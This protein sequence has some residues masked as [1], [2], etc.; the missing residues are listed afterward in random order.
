MYPAVP[1]D[2]ASA[3]VQLM[4]YAITAVVAVISFVLS[5]R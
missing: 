5:M 3:A 1:V 2:V 4:S